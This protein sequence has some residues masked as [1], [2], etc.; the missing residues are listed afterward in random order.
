MRRRDFLLATSAFLSAPIAARAQ[1]VAKK[2][3]AL[4]SPSTKV[5]E[6]KIGGEAFFGLLLSEL[7]PLGYAEGENLIVDRYSGEG[8]QDRYADVARDVIATQPDVIFS[9]G[10]PMTLRFKR[11]G[12]TIPVVALTGDPIRFGIVSS[13]ANPGGNITGVSVD[14]GIE[15]WPKRLGFL[16]EAVPNLTS[17]VFVA[18]KGGWDGPGGKAT[19]E[20]AEKLGISVVDALVPSPFNEAEFLR[21]LDAIPASSRGG[22]VMS[23][24]AETYSNRAVILDWIKKV[25]TAAIFPYRDMT[26]RG[27]LMSYSWSL[28]S[29]ARNH[30]MLIAKILRGANPGDLPYLQEARFELTFNLKTANSLGL[31]APSALLARADAVIE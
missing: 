7:K 29:V 20:A 1:P 31:A 10:T 9:Q 14:A 28:N 23:D 17:I 5:A 21:I 11:S 27:G 25:R 22:V 30:A 15:M 6:M 19:R 13:L 3:L 18:T 26:E 24:E 8:N 4:V 12:T 2:R 16:V